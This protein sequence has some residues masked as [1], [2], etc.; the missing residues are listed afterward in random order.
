MIFLDRPGG[1]RVAAITYSTKAYLA[2]NLGDN[3]VDNVDKA[4]EEIHKIRY[5]GG[6]TATREGLKMIQDNMD[7]ISEKAKAIILITDGRHNFGGMC[8]II[9]FIMK[10]RFSIS[11]AIFPIRILWGGVSFMPVSVCL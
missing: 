1:T 6:G 3:S 8:C 10:D 4:C 11:G 7:L 9:Q 2:F 5:S